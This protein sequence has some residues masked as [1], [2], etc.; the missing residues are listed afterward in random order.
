MNTTTETVKQTQKQYV[1]ERISEFKKVMAN[2]SMAIKYRLNEEMEFAINDLP[3]SLINELHEIEEE[4]LLCEPT[5]YLPN[6]RLT[7]RTPW[8]KITLRGEKKEIHIAD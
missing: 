7:I 6:W 4:S 2:N 8:G 1:I 5:P 3:D